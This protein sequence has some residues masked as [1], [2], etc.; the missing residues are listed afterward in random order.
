MTD[1]PKYRR[2]ADEII[3]KIQAGE[4]APGDLIP[5]IRALRA[6]GNGERVVHEA[7]RVLRAEGWIRTEVGA[8]TYVASHL[9]EVDLTLEQRVAELERWRAEVEAQTQNDPTQ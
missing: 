6:A 8:G 5:S 4:Y 7:L 3:K 2:L 1:G 9:P